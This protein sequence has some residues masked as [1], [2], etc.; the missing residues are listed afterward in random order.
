MQARVSIEQQPN[1]WRS[2]FVAALLGSGV[3]VRTLWHSTGAKALNI[4]SRSALNSSA[5]STSQGGGP[6]LHEEVMAQ[7]A[8]NERMS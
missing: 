4:R 6:D 2:P 1:R 3:A 8:D 5:M 7:L